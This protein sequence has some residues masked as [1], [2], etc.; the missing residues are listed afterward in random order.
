MKTLFLITGWLLM[1]VVLA[2]Y[3]HAQ[4]ALDSMKAIQRADA[5]LIA[6]FERVIDTMR[7]D[8]FNTTS[9]IIA[10][11]DKGRERAPRH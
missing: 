8:V 6:D 7:F 9:D 1:F 4:V 10:V 11:V 3:I 2:G 5:E